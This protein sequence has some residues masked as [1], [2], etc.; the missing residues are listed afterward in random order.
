MKKNNQLK[1]EINF[2]CPDCQTIYQLLEIHLGKRNSN[3]YC[4]DKWKEILAEHY[5]KEMLGFLNEKE[6]SSEEETSHH[7]EKQ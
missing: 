5:H 6:S 3:C 1:K 4:L 2:K 7:H